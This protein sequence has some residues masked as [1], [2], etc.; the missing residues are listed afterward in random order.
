MSEYNIVPPVNYFF[1]VV[2]GV[3][4]TKY[5]LFKFSFGNKVLGTKG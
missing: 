2:L 3:S 5:P 1:A 4:E